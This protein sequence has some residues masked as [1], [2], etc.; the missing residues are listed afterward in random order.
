MKV[1]KESAQ[2]L[3]SATKV[4]VYIYICVC[5]FSFVVLDQAFFVEF[6]QFFYTLRFR[7]LL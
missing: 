6:S 4:F 7:T 2:Y 3:T 1:S 5:D